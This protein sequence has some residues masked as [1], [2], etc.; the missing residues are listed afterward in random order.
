[1]GSGVGVAA[2]VGAVIVAVVARVGKG[3][4]SIFSPMVVDVPNASEVSLSGV[5]V[6]TMLMEGASGAGVKMGIGVA[7]GAPQP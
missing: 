3:V 5:V 4:G 1:M 6:G 7:S 2:S